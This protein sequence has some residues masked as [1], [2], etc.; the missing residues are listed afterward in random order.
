MVLMLSV[1]EGR[2]SLPVEVQHLLQAYPD[3]L[4]TVEDNI[5]YWHNG[6]KMVYDDGVKEKDFEML[7]NYPDIEDQF[8]FMY[9]I[10]SAYHLPFPRNFDPGRIRYEPFFMNMYGWSAEEVQAKLV[11]VS[12]LPATVNKRIWITSVNNVH[13][14]LQAISNEL[15]R[16]PDEF[17]K[18]LIDIGGTFN[19]RAITGTERLSS[20]SFGIAI[21]INVK[22]ANYWKWDNPDPDGEQSYRN[23]IP[24]EIVEI[25][26]KYGF[27]WGGK[28]Y[29]YDT[30]HFEYRPELLLRNF[31]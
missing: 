6:S 20:H 22:Y 4:L 31:E 19:W 12:W 17:K 5:I 29:H 25:F 26:E 24:L 8:S 11:E 23:Q 18:Y 14:K 10:G 16:L 2:D 3:H 21:D 9:P 28:W 30:M 27:I 15:D 7:L 13:E 1:V